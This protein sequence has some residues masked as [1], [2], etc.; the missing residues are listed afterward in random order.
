MKKE[1]IITDIYE[2]AVEKEHLSKEITK[3]KWRILDYE[4]AKY[5][6]KL[7]CA[8]AKCSPRPLSLKLGVHGRF[9]I[10]LGMMQLRGAP[11]KA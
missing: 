8:S 5:S 6:G 7:V 10:Y 9:H 1:I 11:K 4:T 2:A 3:D